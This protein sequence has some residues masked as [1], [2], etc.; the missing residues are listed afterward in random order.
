MTPVERLT[1]AIEKLETLKAESTQGQWVISG[2]WL[3]AVQPAHVF[4]SVAVGRMD[5]ERDDALVVTLHRTIDAQLAILR[6]GLEQ[7]KSEEAY[8]HYW[9]APPKDGTLALA[10]AILGDS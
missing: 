3:H 1:A 8:P 7:A 10:D 2:A 5:H 6:A 9:Y 4:G